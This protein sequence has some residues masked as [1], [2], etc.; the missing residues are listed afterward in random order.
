MTDTLLLHVGSHRSA[1]FAGPSIP[2][3]SGRRQTPPSDGS[4]KSCSSGTAR[5][6]MWLFKGSAVRRQVA[7]SVV[8]T[9]STYTSYNM[10]PFS[11]FS[12]ASQPKTVQL[13]AG[14]DWPLSGYFFL[15]KNS[16]EPFHGRNAVCKRTHLRRVMNRAI[17]SRIGAGSGGSRCWVAA[18]GKQSGRASAIGIWN[19]VLNTRTT[20]SLAIPRSR[21]LQ[22]ELGLARHPRA[23]CRTPRFERIAAAK[24]K[25][26]EVENRLPSSHRIGSTSWV[27]WDR[28][29]AS[30]PSQHGRL[31]PEIRR[32]SGLPESQP[33][34]L[35]RH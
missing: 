30:R 10:R 11:I 1:W 33:P 3:M 2:L 6:L 15:N 25:R 20:R 7:A 5:L 32:C 4:V 29:A 34:T 21:P 28:L 27:W 35:R 24:H 13:D 23:A 19:C 9:S 26:A 8:R 14:S 22:L 17:A 31:H 16:S 12:N 18:T